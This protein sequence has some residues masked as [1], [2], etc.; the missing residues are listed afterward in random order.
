MVIKYKENF[1]KR[2]GSKIEVLAQKKP[3]KLEQILTKIDKMI[4]KFENKTNLSSE[5]KDKIISQLIAIKE[6]VED[7]LEETELNEDNELNVE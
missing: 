7:K 6:M 5:K 4:E 1:V 2:I 3:E